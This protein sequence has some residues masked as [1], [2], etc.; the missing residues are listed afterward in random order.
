MTWFWMNHFSAYEDQAI[1]PHALGKF[2]DLLAA[3]ARSPAM[4][5]Y[6]DNIRNS[7]GH[8]NENYA[9]ELLELHT[10]GVQ[11]GYSQRD[12]QELARVLTG[13]GLNQTGEAPRVKPAQRAAG[14]RRPVPVRTGA[15]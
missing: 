10:L 1:R 15:P 7:A 6:L 9:R 2:R 12:V 3:T 14:R 8:I 11:G 4:L 5:I 13:V